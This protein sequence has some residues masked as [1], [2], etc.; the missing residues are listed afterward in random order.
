MMLNKKIDFIVIGTQK[1]GTTALDYYLR[2][3]PEVGMGKRK[4][5]HFFD[6]ETHF[7]N[8]EID[9]SKYEGQ[10][11]TSSYKKAYG[12]ATP[13]YL[14]WKQ[15][16]RRI[17]EYNQNIKLI[18]ILRNPIERA[19]SHWNMEYDR[20]KEKKDFL[21][22]INNES[23]RMKE[24][25]SEQHR[26]F[27]YLDRGFYSLQLKRYLKY[28]SRDQMLFVKYEDFKNQ[29]AATLHKVFN[30]LQIKPDKFHFKPKIIHKRVYRKKMTMETK[31]FLINTYKNDI[32][33]VE[34]L[35]KWDCKS[36]LR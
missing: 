34:S 7:Q 32:E 20:N 27:S 23:N 24:A 1:G 14:Y 35:L 5:L 11:E 15:S 25:S 17:W 26:V 9:Y 33:Q 28:F 31:S 12:E 16:C 30:F 2:Q 22:C 10:F 29:Q 8:K 19:F 21:Y 36:W 18:A 4:E 13:I 6:N 3:H